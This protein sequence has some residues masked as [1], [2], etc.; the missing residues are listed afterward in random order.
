[1][2]SYEFCETSKNTFFAVQVWATASKYKEIFY[3]FDLKNK[4]FV[5]I[6]S[7]VFAINRTDN[8]Y[9]ETAPYIIIFS[10]VMTPKLGNKYC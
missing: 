5:R 1:M 2:F 3:T 10:V 7:K 8:Y 9:R 6:T 4:I